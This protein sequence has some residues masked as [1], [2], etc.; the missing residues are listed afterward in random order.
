MYIGVSMLPGQGARAQ[1]LE[2]MISFLGLLL[3]WIY[4]VT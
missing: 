2:E 1:A 3:I 4:K